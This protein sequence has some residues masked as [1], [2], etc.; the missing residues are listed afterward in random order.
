MTK[1]REEVSILILE[2]QLRLDLINHIVV[3]NAIV[4]SSTK[5]L[6]LR[7]RKFLKVIIVKKVHLINVNDDE[8]KL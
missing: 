2:A 7:V 3:L 1:S 8:V 5:Q 4:L 6:I